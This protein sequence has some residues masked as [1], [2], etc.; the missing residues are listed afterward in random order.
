M[1]RDLN[2]WKYKENVVHNHKKV[3]KVACCDGK[4]MDELEMLPIEEILKKV[5]VVFSDWTIEDNGNDYEKENHGAF[6]IFTTSQI[7][8]FDCYN[9]REND[10]NTLMDILIEFGCPLYDSQISTRFDDWTDR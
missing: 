5:S 10:M 9:M 8:R 6:Q 2:F 3:Y 7:V 1:S 4:L